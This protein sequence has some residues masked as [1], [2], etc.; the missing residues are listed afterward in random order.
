MTTPK[1]ECEALLAFVL[2]FAEHLLAKRG[3]FLP[4]GG[5]IKADGAMTM[6]HGAGETERPL[7]VDILKLLKEGFV[8]F[9]RK[10]EYRAT[11]AVYET[12]ST[13]PGETEKLDA[14]T[15]SLNHRDDYS[16]R[17][18]FPFRIDDGKIVWGESFAQ[19]GEADIFPE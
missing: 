15:V 1:S 10:G 8:L 2:P 6:I 14:V 9:A 3:G 5:V 7:P 12:W 18:V 17:V 13:R 4:Y 16:V 11:A 19:S